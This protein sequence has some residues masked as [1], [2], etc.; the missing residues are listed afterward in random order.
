MP[1]TLE[2]LFSPTATASFEFLNETVTVEYCPWRWTG[3]MQS[4]FDTFSRE[5]E[6]EAERIAELREAGD[7]AAVQASERK[8]NIANKRL[9]REMLA[10]DS[11][12]GRPAGLLVA[13]DVMRGKKAVVPTLAELNRLP[14]FFLTCVFLALGTENAPDPQTAPNSDEPSNTERTSV[15][16]PT[17]TGSSRGRGSLASHR[18]SSTNGR[19]GRSVTRSGSRGPASQPASNLRSA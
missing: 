17:G 4:V 1:I 7:M 12:E 15:S 2:K 11:A 13:W 19:N 8:L 16:S 10:C 6:E 5:E 3:E 14:D 9:F 18:S